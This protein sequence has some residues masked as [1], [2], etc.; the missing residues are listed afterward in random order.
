MKLQATPTLA[1]RTVLAQLARGA[2]VIMRPSGEIPRY[3]VMVS[4][5]SARR[6]SARMIASLQFNGWVWSGP[7][8]PSFVITQRERAAIHQPIM[9]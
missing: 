8:R 9:R 1:Q 6:V 5:T 3:V 2:I 7:D 4:E